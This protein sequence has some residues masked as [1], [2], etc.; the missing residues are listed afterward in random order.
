[1]G[2]VDAAAAIRRVAAAPDDGRP[3]ASVPGPGTA[4]RKVA[5]PMQAPAVASVPTSGAGQ[6]VA[7]RATT[8]TASGWMRAAGTAPAGDAGPCG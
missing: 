2:C 6:P 5:T 7:V 4:L 8:K 3:I 1:M